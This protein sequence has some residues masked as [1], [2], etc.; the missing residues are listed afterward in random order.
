MISSPTTN[1]LS[2]YSIHK[3]AIIR[4]G[5]VAKHVSSMFNSNAQILLTGTGVA[6]TGNLEIESLLLSYSKSSHLIV[7]EKI[8]SC[9]AS[10][11][12][13]VEEA[14]VTIDHSEMIAWLL[15]GVRPTGREIT[16]ILVTITTWDSDGKITSKKVY[17]DQAS[18]L[19]QIS[20]LP[21]SLYCKANSSEV[22]LPVAGVEM[23]YKVSELIAT[24]PASFVESF[25][26][27]KVAE[28]SEVAPENKRVNPNRGAESDIFNVDQE[29]EK[30]RP[31]SRVLAQPGGKTSDIFGTS[32]IDVNSSE[33]TH[34]QGKQHGN[35][36]SHENQEAPE[37]FRS[38]RTHYDHPVDSVFDDSPIVAP[39]LTRRDPNWSS[40]Q[41][42]PA[43]RS[44]R[45]YSGKTNQSSI[46]FGNH[47][48]EPAEKTVPS[49]RMVIEHQK[50]QIDFSESPIVPLHGY[51]RRD[52]NARSVETSMRP[53]SR[54][55]NVPGG[56]SSFSFA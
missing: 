5:S 54:V 2:Q 6:A 29:P 55:L 9:V 12:Q 51:A 42:I 25:Q 4:G 43:G 46:S 33:R 41:A 45:P 18:V 27:L 23:A 11:F 22:I 16:I 10:Q 7:E 14:A 52:P 17:W 50:S 26:T 32:Q 1:L 3:Q 30:Y 15:P 44:T 48:E 36:L 35:I 56:K 39:H 24:T 8:L 37:K 47:Y 19:R 28:D 21:R 31:S 49:R 53:S 40:E 20:V 13:V 34:F 38:G